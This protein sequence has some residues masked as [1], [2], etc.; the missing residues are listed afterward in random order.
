M[1]TLNPKTAKIN[2]INTGD[3]Y[4]RMP[5]EVEGTGGDV[6]EAKKRRGN[7]IRQTKG[8]DTYGPMA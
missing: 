6:G 1:P 8:L 5:V 7:V 2:N 3:A 4:G